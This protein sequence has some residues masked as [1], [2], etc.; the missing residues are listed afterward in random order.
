MAS[1]ARRKPG[2]GG[3]GPYPRGQT[4][5]KGAVLAELSDPAAASDIDA[6][7]AS[8]AEAR[9]NLAALERGGH[10]ADFADIDNSLARARLD[11][12]REQKDYATLQRLDA[13]QAAT[14]VEVQAAADKSA[15]RSWKSRAWKSAGPRWW[16]RPRW[17]PRKPAW[18]MPKWPWPR[19]AAA[20]PRGVLRAPMAGEVYGLAVRPGAYL[21]AGDLVA[22]VGRLDRV[23]V[24]V[25]VDE[26]LLGR[27]APG[28]PVTITWEALPGKQWH[29]TV[30]QMPT[31]IQTLG[32]R[33]VGEVVCTI[34]NPGRDLIPGTN[35]DAEIRTACRRTGA[36]DSQ[37][38]PA[39]RCR[40]RLRLRPAA[41]T[42]SSGAP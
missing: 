28:Q 2:P 6:A 15:S 30:E 23:R 32:S 34:E 5:A 41:A 27:V 1:G 25:Y 11:L 19:P 4:V 13:K 12:E 20:P 35:V 14:A 7:E 36:G 10:P 17:M 22:N 37:G 38:G 3:R 39:P 31:S 42:P 9:A 33:Q 18:P 40:R 29:G 21:N 24:R 16:I 26:P 8:V